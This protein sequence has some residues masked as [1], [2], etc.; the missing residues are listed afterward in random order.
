MSYNSGQIATSATQPAKDLMDTL[1]TI[2][3]SH[4]AWVFVEEVT[5]TGTNVAQVFKC[6]G[7]SNSWGTDFFMALVRT[8]LTSSV[9]V[10]LFETYD[11]TAKTGGKPAI[12]VVGSTGF[13]PAADGSY[14]TPKHV[15]NENTVV[16]VTAGHLLAVG[17]E[18]GSVGG[19]STSTSAATN[20]WIAVT[21][22]NVILKVQVVGGGT[23]SAVVGWYDSFH[24]SSVDFAPLMVMPVDT[25]GSYQSQTF[26]AYTREP[27]SF[28]HF[29]NFQGYF[30]LTSYTPRTPYNFLAS[31][32][33]EAITG[34]WWA[35]RIMLVESGRRNAMRGLVEDKL[36]MLDM[37]ENAESIGDEVSIDGVVHTCLKTGTSGLWVSQAA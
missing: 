24:T 22:N 4:A 12:Y 17:Q 2:I 10:C 33:K 14:A 34:K 21:N 13:G 30:D 35:S 7:T 37:G 25:G 19:I 36:V 15:A 9:G 26:G 28:A 18:N 8:S 1:K 31:Q 27:A 3:D 20:Y 6:L 5:G 11:S 23:G 29:Y 16:A 32:T